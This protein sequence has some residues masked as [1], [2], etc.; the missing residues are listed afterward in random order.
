M[1]RYADD[2]IIHCRTQHE[3]KQLLVKVT[4]RLEQCGLRVHG[5]KTRIVYCKKEGRKLKGL[6]VQFD[7]LGF[8]F[9]PK[10]TKLRKGGYFLQYDCQMSRKSKNRILKD[11]R[12]MN[13]HNHTQSK[14][15]RIGC[16]AKP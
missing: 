16:K 8:S 7:F 5:Q 9:R 2:I 11:L 1:V 15:T 10:M 3:A 4:E 12:A 13:I 14:F 6:P